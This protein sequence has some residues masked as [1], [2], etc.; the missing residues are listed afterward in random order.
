MKNNPLLQYTSNTY[1]QFG[2]DGILTEIF[3]RI[4]LNTPW[5]VEFGAWDGI[6]FSNTR[7]LIE[8]GWNAVLIEP[9]PRKFKVLVKNNQ[10][11]P[12]THL[13]QKFITLT[14]ETSLDNLLVTTPIP[15]QFDLLSIDIDG[16][17]YHIWKSIE[18]YD[19][20]V[21]VIEYNPTI[22][23]D[24]EFIQPADFSVQQGTS[25]KALY[26]LAKEKKYEL[27][28]CTEANGI[29]VKKKYFPL[30]NIKDNSPEV[31]Q[32]NKY[33]TRIY[34]LFDGTIK[35]EGTTKL[36]WSDISFS[37]NDIQILPKFLR[38]FPE[39]IKNILFLKMFHFWRNSFRS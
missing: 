1:S 6:A 32:E 31:M 10:Q 24:I 39:G 35:I 19:P 5:C 21:V 28:A 23:P 33:L 14:G 22:P 26:D 12:K 27:I 4:K 17:D 9:N 2:E 25:L 3:R 38:R 30:F 18:K 11:F 13:L 8:Q 29:F 15:K 20:K 16:N 7:S 34:Q 36:L 37:E